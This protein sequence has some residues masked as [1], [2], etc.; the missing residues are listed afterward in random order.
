M[1]SR[2]IQSARVINYV[3][4]MSEVTGYKIVI[5]YVLTQSLKHYEIVPICSDVSEEREIDD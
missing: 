2:R 4:M 5:V 3:V 1:S